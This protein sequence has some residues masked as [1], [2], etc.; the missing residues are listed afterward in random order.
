MEG[1]DNFSMK[2]SFRCSV[3]DADLLAYFDGLFN[4]NLEFKCKLNGMKYLKHL[5][6]GKKYGLLSSNKLLHFKYLILV[7]QTSYL[8]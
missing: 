8:H 1:V 6:T 7:Q 3:L 4:D 2:F 5:D